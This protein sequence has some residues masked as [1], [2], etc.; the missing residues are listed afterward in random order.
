MSL[1]AKRSRHVAVA[2][3]STYSDVLRHAIRWWS[4]MICSGSGPER[5]STKSA[6]L[7]VSMTNLVGTLKDGKEFNMGELLCDHLRNSSTRFDEITGIT[8]TKNLGSNL[9]QAM[10]ITYLAIK[11]ICPEQVSKG[12]K[13]FWADD[14]N[15]PPP[16]PEPGDP[17]PP[18]ITSFPTTATN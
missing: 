18:D 9:R 7:K 5:D 6:P 4:Q 2:G 12:A 16:E 13:Q 10:V 14:V 15:T 8:D 1:E 3:R 17:V 11:D